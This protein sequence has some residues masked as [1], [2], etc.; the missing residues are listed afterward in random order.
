[1]GHYDTV[2]CARQHEDSRVSTACLQI[3]RQGRT[4]YCGRGEHVPTVQFLYSY[5]SS[6]SVYFLY[7]TWYYTIFVSACQDNSLLF[8]GI[9]LGDTKCHM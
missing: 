5:V 7:S 3:M 8:V 4:N 1:M 6:L 9:S 2:G